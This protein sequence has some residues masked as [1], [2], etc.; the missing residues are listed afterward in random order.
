MSP[1]ILAL[2]E[3]LWDCFPA[4]RQFGGAPANVACQAARLGG[5]ASLLSAV[6]DDAEGREALAILE[7]NG[8]DTS[9]IQ[10]VTGAET[11]RVDVTVDAAGKPSFCIRPSAAWDRIA[12]TAGIEAALAGFDAVD[13]G[14]LGQRSEPSRST[15]RRVLDVARDRGVLRVLDVNLRPPFDGADVINESVKRA[16]VLKLSDDELPAVTAACG[17]DPDSNAIVALQALQSRYALKLV[18]MTRGAA[19]AVLVT[20]TEVSEQPGIPTAVVDTVGAGDAFT[21]S[22]S[23]GFLRGHSPATLA[24]TACELASATCAHAGAVPD[25][26]PAPPTGNRS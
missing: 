17:I 24:R 22:L 10:L 16:D 20:S 3:V 19:G 25:S 13:F 23:V 12:W 7:R 1:T 18:A 6:G 26:L 21:A 2:G 11:G 4:G 9:M 15:I 8:V 14:T 5:R